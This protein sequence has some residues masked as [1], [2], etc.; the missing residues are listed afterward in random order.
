MAPEKERCVLKILVVDDFELFRRIMCSKLQSRGGFHITQA[1]DGFE[2]VQKAEDLQP[3]LILLDIGLP[4]LDGIE[5]ARRVGKV[6]PLAKILFLS[7]ESD[8]DVIKVALGLGALGYI[9]KSRIERDLLPAIHAAVAGEPFVTFDLA[10]A[11]PDTQHYLARFTVKPTPVR[12]GK[13]GAHKVGKTAWYSKHLQK[14]ERQVQT[15]L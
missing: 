12:S 5:V 2:A 14:R 11:Q 8:P 13:S 3:D 15:Y 10:G 6:A 4:K 9:H 7:V 1:S